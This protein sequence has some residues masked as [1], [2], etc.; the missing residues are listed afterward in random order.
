[1]DPRQQPHPAQ[2]AGQGPPRGRPA[3]PGRQRAG[4]CHPHLARRGHEGGRRHQDARR[5]VP[6]RPAGFARAERSGAVPAAGRR[7]HL[8]R[9]QHPGR[10]PAYTA[11][12]TRDVTRL[13]VF[14]SSDTS[15]ADVNVTGLVEFKGTGEVAVLV[16]YLMELNTVRLT[17]LEP[18]KDFTWKAP[19]E[20]NYV[21]KHVFAKLKMLSIQPSELCTDSEFVRRAYLDLCGVLPTPDEVKKFLDD[22]AKDKRAKLIDVLLE[23]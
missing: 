23:R 21:D 16:R 11:G 15:V 6:G 13:S 8:H 12:S 10:G 4:P 18:R 17:Y 22:T 2:V 1:Q 3:L 14:S 7:R 9:R 20:N 19:P 5:Q